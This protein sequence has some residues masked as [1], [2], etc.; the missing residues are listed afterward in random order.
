VE[1]VKNQLVPLWVSFQSFKNLKWRVGKMMGV[2]KR[3]SAPLYVVTSPQIHIFTK[4]PLIGA[5]LQKC[6]H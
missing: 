4:M 1:N 6:H 3:K 2:G 5:K